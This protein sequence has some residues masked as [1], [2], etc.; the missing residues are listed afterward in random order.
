M[1]NYRRFDWSSLETYNRTFMS[2]ELP[3]V[4]HEKFWYILRAKHANPAGQRHY[5]AGLHSQ[6]TPVDGSLEREQLT[7]GKQSIDAFIRTLQHK[8]PAADAAEGRRRGI[9]YP[10]GGTKQVPLHKP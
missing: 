8:T 10:A 5:R 7:K 2:S 6:I 9:V 1:T 4:R 3:L